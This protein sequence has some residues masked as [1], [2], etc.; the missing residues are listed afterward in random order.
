MI[1]KVKA[2]ALIL[3]VLSTSASVVLLSLKPQQSNVNI[4]PT[5]RVCSVAPM[6]VYKV[7]EHYKSFFQLKS[8]G[9]Y[10][11]WVTD[12]VSN[13]LFYSDEEFKE[14]DT[15]KIVLDKRR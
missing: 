7:Q 8:S 4:R 3:L 5:D 11:Y 13:W 6:V 14:G 1:E 12:E 9:R 15:V 10:E 2:T